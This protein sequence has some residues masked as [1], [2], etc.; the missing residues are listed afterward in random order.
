MITDKEKTGTN[1]GWRKPLKNN[2]LIIQLP[3]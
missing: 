2:K 3:H 1:S